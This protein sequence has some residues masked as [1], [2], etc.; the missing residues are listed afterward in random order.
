MTPKR[1]NAPAG[2]ARSCPPSDADIW[3]AAAFADYEQIV[4]HEKAIRARAAGGKLGIRDRER[5]ALACLR[6][7]RVT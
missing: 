4:A 6:R 7:L 1:I 2:T 5:L 3:L